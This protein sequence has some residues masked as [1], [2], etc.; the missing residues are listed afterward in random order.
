MQARAI[1]RSIDLDYV[2]RRGGRRK[3]RCMSFV[4]WDITVVEDWSQLLTFRGVGSAPQAA[5]QFQVSEIA[6]ESLIRPRKG[7]KSRLG[8]SDLQA[9]STS[10]VAHRPTHSLTSSDR[11]GRT[12]GN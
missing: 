1:I 4:L 5:S 9:L 2:R 7:T 10:T 6:G 11:M 12:C 3:T 8:S